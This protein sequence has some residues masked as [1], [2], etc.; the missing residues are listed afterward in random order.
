MDKVWS[1][2]FTTKA[3]GAGLGLA[4]CKRLIE[5]HGGTISVESNVGEGSTFTVK[6]PLDILR[7]PNEPVVE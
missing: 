5:A 3:K 2:L 6:L 7:D 1:P 4:V